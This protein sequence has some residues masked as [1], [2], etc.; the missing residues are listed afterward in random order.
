MRI[1]VTGAASPL[2]RVVVQL[3]GA[4]GHRV[5]GLARR[6][7]G[8]KVLEKLGADPFRGDVR[9]KDHV[10]RA[11]AGCDAVIHLAG[12]FD[13]WEPTPGTYESVNV[14]AVRQVIAAA[15]AAGARR[16]VL[17]SSAITIG[18]AAGTHGDEATRH[19]GRTVTALEA[20][21]LEAEQLALRSRGRGLEVVVVNP[22]L[23]VAPGD[24]GWVGRLIGDTVLGRRPLSAH[25]PLGW[26]WVEDAAQGIARAVEHGEDGARYILCGD[27]F[28]SHRF[29]SR[30]AAS[31]DARPPRAMHNGLVM[32]EAALRTAMARPLG[33]RPGVALDEARFL[34]TGFEVSG[35]RA[36]EELE[37][38]YT[39]AARWLPAVARAYRMKPLPARSA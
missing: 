13:F 21:K 39:P 20:S 14:G 37:L 3:L 23:V 33:R 30:I 15:R 2:G 32:A 16:F 17:C 29:L 36:S 11:I 7:S 8:I 35:S 34:T 19:R 26:V 22:G 12:F 5:V 38:E 9:R 6:V 28:S 31:A 10:A 4:R 1:L 27:T 24:P 18:E 25:A